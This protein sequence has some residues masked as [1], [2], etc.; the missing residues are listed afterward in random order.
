[1]KY[2]QQAIQCRDAFNKAWV[3]EMPEEIIQLFAA[4]VEKAEKEN[5][6]DINMTTKYGSSL[7]HLIVV[8][9]EN[10]TKALDILLAHGADINLAQDGDRTPLHLAIDKF[11]MNNQRY[12]FVNFLIE[13]GADIN[14]GDETGKTPLHYVVKLMDYSLSNHSRSLLLPLLE[15]G[16]IVAKQDSDGINAY[17]FLEDKIDERPEAYEIEE[18]EKCLAEL[19]KF[20]EKEK[21][22]AT[23]R[24]IEFKN[25]FVEKWKSSKKPY[26]CLLPTIVSKAKNEGIF[27]VNWSGTGITLLHYAAAYEE[28]GV[29]QLLLDNGADVNIQTT[30]NHE[31]DAGKGYTALHCILCPIGYIEFGYCKWEKIDEQTCHCI[32]LL[33]KHNAKLN[34]PDEKGYTVLNAAIA[35]QQHDNG[36]L[37]NLLIEGQ[38]NHYEKNKLSALQT[39]K[40]QAPSLTTIC[41]FTMQKAFSKSEIENMKNNMSEEVY[42][43]LT[44]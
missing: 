20:Y 31:Y 5:I 26:S 41:I 11:S 21:E 36:F 24:A 2:Y 3:G 6:F 9:A 22:L 32:L 8:T 10:Q 42:S 35:N 17:E 19:K 13:N 18:L 15:H 25:A 40:Y 12:N 4:I 37:Y 30:I 29:L 16:A 44:N 38:N 27:D 34:I 23:Q 43:R 33:L 28:I 14:K 1:M 39:G 7:L